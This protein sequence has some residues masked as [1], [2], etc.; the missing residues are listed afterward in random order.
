MNYLEYDRMP[1]GEVYPYLACATITKNSEIWTEL[2][3]ACGDLCEKFRIW[4]GDQE[5]L[6]IIAKRKSHQQLGFIPEHSYACL[7]EEINHVSQ[8]TFL[9]FKGPAR[10]GLM[11]DFYKKIMSF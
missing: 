3:N 8:A 9:H 11:L 7:P 2:A 6:K 10:K 4:Y 5:A 1:L